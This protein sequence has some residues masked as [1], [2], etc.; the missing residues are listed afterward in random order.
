VVCLYIHKKN[1]DKLLHPVAKKMVAK[2]RALTLEERFKS[3]EDFQRLYDAWEDQE[4]EE[5]LASIA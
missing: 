3:A 5:I 4:V 1:I 2:V